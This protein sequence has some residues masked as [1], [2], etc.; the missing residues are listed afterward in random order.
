MNSIA[1]VFIKQV[2]QTIIWGVLAGECFAHIF[3]KEFGKLCTQQINLAADLFGKTTRG[4]ANGQLC[5]QSH[6]SMCNFVSEMIYIVGNEFANSFVSNFQII[7][8][9]SNGMNKVVNTTVYH[10]VNNIVNHIANSIANVFVKASSY[11]VNKVATNIV[12]KNVESFA[13]SKITW[14]QICLGRTARGNTRGVALYTIASLDVQCCKRNDLH[15]W[16]RIC[17]PF[18]KQ[19]PNN[20][21][22]KHWCKQCIKQYSLP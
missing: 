8:A 10:I 6:R 14:L 11:G 3:D 7:N 18:C 22:R 19:C 9:A 2:S 17:K 21:Y 4:N 5:T 1:H 13:H 16:E 12:Y 15:R 20:Q